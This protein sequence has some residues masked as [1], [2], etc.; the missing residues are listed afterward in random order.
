MLSKKGK[1]K[2][3]GEIDQSQRDL[4]GRHED[5]G[6]F[7]F[8]IASP[9]YMLMLMQCESTHARHEVVKRKNAGLF[10]PT[11]PPH[12]KVPCNCEGQGKEISPT[13]CS[14]PQAA[15]K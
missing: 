2:R 4:I 1:E 5:V 3:K 12:R 6:V 13:T 8:F 14:T 15:S 11:N 9:R 10:P 7:P